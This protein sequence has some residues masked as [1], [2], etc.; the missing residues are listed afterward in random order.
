MLSGHTRFALALAMMFAAIGGARAEQAK[1]FRYK[2]QKDQPLIYRF[3]QTTKQTQ[4]VNGRTIETEVGQTTVKVWTLEKIDEKGNF[5]LKDETR[6]LKA[7]IEIGPLGEYK[8]D[9][10]AAEQES[11]TVLS[12]ALNPVYDQLSTASLTVTV[13]PDGNILSV[14]GYEEL[15]GDLLKDNPLASQLTGGG[16]KEAAKLSLADQFIQF[17]ENPVKPG[18]TWE[19]SYEIELGRI[20]KVQGKQVYTYVGPDKV[21]DR[22]TAK[23]TVTYDLSVDIDINTQGSKVTGT[24]S[25]ADASGTVQFDPENGRIVSKQTTLTLSGNLNI[26]AGD[27]NFTV[28]ISQTQTTK[29]ELLDKL[30]ES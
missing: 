7:K 4:K 2:M 16:S 13:A 14:E 9:S 17:G 27:Q 10:T 25:T 8:Y 1:T 11:G 6:Q 22:P 18:D 21:G 28:E 15:L 24:L 12:E 20:G 3:T 19:K 26:S 23:F 29:L 5:H 30:P